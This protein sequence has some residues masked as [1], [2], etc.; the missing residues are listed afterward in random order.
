MDEMK[1]TQTLNLPKTLTIKWLKE[2]YQQNQLKPKDVINEIIRRVENDQEMNIWIT[3]PTITRLQPYFDSLK[4]M[5]PNDTP[6]WGIPFAIKDNIDLINIST[7]AGCPEY[8]YTPNENATVVQRLIQAGAIPLGKTNLDQFATGLVGTRSPYG[9]VHN[10]LKSEL[11]SGGSSSGSAVSVARGHAVFSL[12]TD[13][14]GSGRI[15]AGLNRLIGLKPSFG[16]WPIKGV[17]PACQSLDCVTVFTH[18]LDDAIF[19]DTIVRGIDKTD[20][21]SRDIRRQLSS[22]LPEKIYFINDPPIEF[23]GPY[24][25]EYQISWQKTIEYIKQ[26]N[27]PIEYID[28]HY[29]VEASSILYGGPWIAER[30]SDLGEFITCQPPNTV[31]PVTE[32]I[33]HSGTNSNH[34]AVSLFKAIHQLQKFKLRAHQQLENAV[35]I[36]PTSG[37]TWTREQVRENPIQTNNDMGRYTNHC[38]LLDLCAIAIPSDDAATEV[39]FGITLFS[40]YD[41][42]HIVLSLADLFL[43]CKSTMTKIP[44]KEQQETPTTTLVVV[45]GLHMRGLPLEKQMLEYKA[46]FIREDETAPYYKLYKLATTPAKPGLVR[47]I[48]DNNEGSSIK[49][50]VWEMPL[51]SF[52]AFTAQIPSPLGIGK[53]ILKDGS[54]APGFVCES[55][56]IHNAVDITPLRSWRT[57]LKDSVI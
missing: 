7:T 38:N 22:T 50:E 26:L 41:N 53:I 21:W 16:A 3:P 5:N 34:T 45:C 17:V 10:A 19:I 35:L 57:F 51:S 24:A 54:Q 6:L 18:E 1:E 40:K 48:E 20:P 8:T 31:F 15:P 12:G 27:I 32:K 11:I 44:I 36:M 25:S 56:A 39:P 52:G 46:K 14:A 9:E 55:Y 29:L 4:K 43:K 49:V 13:T 30:W 47:T 28:G 37:G 42:E 2:K 23:F 33:L